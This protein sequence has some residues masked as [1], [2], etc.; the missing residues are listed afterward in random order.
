M[1]KP[2]EKIILQNSYFNEDDGPVLKGGTVG[3]MGSLK[4]ARPVLTIL[5]FKQRPPA[6]FTSDGLIDLMQA[7]NNRLI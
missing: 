3:K 1:K 5:A 2:Q 7:P 6:G 4:N